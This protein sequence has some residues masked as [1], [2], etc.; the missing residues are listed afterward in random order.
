V[1]LQ[2]MLQPG[3][4]E[5]VSSRCQTRARKRNS[6]TVS[7]PTGQTSAAQADHGFV[8]GPPSKVSM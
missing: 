2:P 6:L 5:S 3:Q 8:E 1:T 7:A 4:I